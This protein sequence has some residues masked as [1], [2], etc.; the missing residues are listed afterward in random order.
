MLLLCSTLLMTGS[1]LA[2]DA[3]ITAYGTIKT[4]DLQKKSFGVVTYEGQLIEII[5]EDESTLAKFRDGRV[6]VGD[7]CK[8]KFRTVDGRN[9]ATYFRKPIGC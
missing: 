1:A 8:V 4:I 7:D 2:D 6:R 3:V 9:I 5:I